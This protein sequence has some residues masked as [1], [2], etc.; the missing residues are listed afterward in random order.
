MSLPLQGPYDESAN[1]S[2]SPWWASL[3][4]PL[5]S[6]RYCGR[7]CRVKRGY[8]GVSSFSA[9]DEQ[10]LQSLNYFWL[11]SFFSLFDVKSPPT[12]FPIKS[13][14]S[15]G[16][17]VSRSLPPGGMI[18]SDAPGV[19]RTNLSPINPRAR[20]DAMASSWILTPS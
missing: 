19:I 4:Y 20:T 1:Q 8:D 6:F 9:L 13:A 17:S 16:D 10:R 15:G 7:A 12:I 5:S 11:S 3:S 14:I 2:K 18:L